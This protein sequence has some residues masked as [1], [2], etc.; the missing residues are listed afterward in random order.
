MNLQKT[1]RDIETTVD[2]VKAFSIELW[3]SKHDEIRMEME[4]HARM[5]QPI[6]MCH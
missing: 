2:T 5:T 6:L 1:T 3:L 4:M